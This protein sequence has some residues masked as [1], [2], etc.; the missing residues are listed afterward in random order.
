M[1][2]ASLSAADGPGQRLPAAAIETQVR[3]ALGRRLS[4]AGSGAQMHLRQPLQDQSLP[5]GRADIVVGETAGRLPRMHVAVPVRLLVDGRLVRTLTVWMD[6]RDERQVLSY[7]AGYAAR[8]PGADLRL[9]TATVDMAC[10]AGETVAAAQ[11]LA[12]LRLKRS[13]RAGQPV[14]ASDFEALPD[15]QAQRPVAIEVA[16]GQVRLT[17]AGIALAD[18][19]IGDE[20]PVRTAASRETVKA[21][22]VAKQKVIVDE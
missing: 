7:A 16:L 4:E 18:G 5:A 11:Q 20:V 15:V 3:E 9:Q 2:V 1:L 21:H 6:L 22:V 8:Q 17:T 19:R 14:L 10:C 12:E 13:V